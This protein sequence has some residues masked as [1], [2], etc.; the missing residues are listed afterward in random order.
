MTV[1][2][3]SIFVG[4]ST[5]ELSTVHYSYSSIRKREMIRR[6]TRSASRIGMQRVRVVFSVFISQLLIPKGAPLKAG[7][8]LSLCF[9]RGGRV[10]ATS[11]FIYEPEKNSVNPLNDNKVCSCTYTC[12]CQHLKLILS[13]TLL[14]SLLLLHR[15]CARTGHISCGYPRE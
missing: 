10:S 7:A 15:Y 6:V 12:Y 4:E 8:V 9:E 5:E 11:N 14:L 1:E 3:K 13:T 2:I